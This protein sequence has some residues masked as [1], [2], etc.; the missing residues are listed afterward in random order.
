MVFAAASPAEAPVPNTEEPHH[1]FQFEN[2]LVRV[3]RVEVAAKEKT[4]L[5]QHDL[6]Y[7]FVVLG[8]AEFINA[9]SGKDPVTV[10]MHDGEDHV[11]KGG[12]AHIATNLLTTPFRNITVEYKDNANQPNL[13]RIPL[14][15]NA[16]IDRPDSAPAALLV[17]LEPAPIQVTPAG[18]AAAT[19]RPGD[20][21]W[22]AHG[23]A[24]AIANHGKTG[25]H[26]LAFEFK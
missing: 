9:V 10:K 26:I 14:P 11:S 3:W 24:A 6:D 2:N 19:L 7:C 16:K 18:Q 13:L 22:I 23:T 12:F 20:S 15:P 1:H 25:G 5:H 8:R 4:L 21:I 17:A